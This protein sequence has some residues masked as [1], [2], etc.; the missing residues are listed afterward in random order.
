M[1]Q[2]ALLVAIGI[3]LHVFENLLPITY[4]LPAPGAK[5]GLANIVTLLALWLYGP[6]EALGVVL[7]RSVLG[8]LVAGTFMTLTFGLSFAGAM[9]SGLAMGLVVYAAAGRFSVV[10]TSIIGAIAHNVAQLAVAAVVIYHWGIMFYLP[11]LLL[12][13]LPTGFFNGLVVTYVLRLRHRYQFPAGEE[14]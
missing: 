11:Y 7:M 9:G 13:A 6:R 8:S 14:G 2:L 3:A 10:G 4:M 1:V 12:F 5:L